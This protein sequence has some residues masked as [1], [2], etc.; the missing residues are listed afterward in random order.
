MSTDFNVFVI[1]ES[2]NLQYPC[3]PDAQDPV[4]AVAYLMESWCKLESKSRI[5]EWNKRARD[6][7][8]MECEI[9]R[10]VMIKLSNARKLL[11]SGG[12][13]AVEE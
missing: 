9:R 2:H 1:Q 4:I 7:G 13:E 6:M 3:I 10:F 8:L 12:S 11:C 5:A